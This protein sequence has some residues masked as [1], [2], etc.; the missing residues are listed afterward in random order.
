MAESFS[1]I[2]FPYSLFLSL[3]LSKKSFSTFALAHGVFRR[4]FRLEMTLGSCVK[5]LIRILAPISFQP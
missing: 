4:N 1:F 3:R 5:H 2:L